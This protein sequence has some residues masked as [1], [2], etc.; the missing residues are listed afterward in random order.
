MMIKDLDMS[1][2][3]ACEDLSAVRGGSNFGL[4]RDRLTPSW[5][6]MR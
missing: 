6:R 5:T 2:E 1:K 4:Y 3:L